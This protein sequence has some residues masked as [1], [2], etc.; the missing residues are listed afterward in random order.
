MNNKMEFDPNKI[1]LSE[2]VT[3]EVSDAPPAAKVK[4]KKSKAKN[5][6]SAYADIPIENKLAIEELDAILE[7][8]EIVEAKPEAIAKPEAVAEPETVAEPEA[9][10]EAPVIEDAPAESVVNEEPKP[11]SFCANCGKAIK[12]DEKFCGNCGENTSQNPVTDEAPAVAVAPAAAIMDSP[13]AAPE[14][15]P[16]VNIYSGNAPAPEE[17]PADETKTKKP[18]FKRF[19]MFFIPWKGD[20]VR[21]VIRKVIFIVALIVFIVAFTFL[22]IYLKNR[23]IYEGYVKRTE[24]LV[25]WDNTT[26]GTDGVLNKYRTLYDKNNDFRGWITIPNTNVDGAVY[27]TLDNSYY[28]NHNGEKKKSNYGAYFVDYKCIISEETSSQNITIYGHHMRDQTMFAQIRKYKDISFYKKNPVIKFETL[29]GGGE[30]KV[31]AAFIT[32]ANPAE[33]NGYFFDYAV[34]GFINQEDFLAWVEQVRRRSLLNTTVDVVEGDDILTLSTCTYELG[35]SKDMR[36]VVMARKI[37]DGESSTVN[38]S[39]ATQNSKPLYPAAW[40]KRFGSKKPTFSDGQ[41]TWGPT[42]NSET[43]SVIEQVQIPSRSEDYS[44]YSPSSYT[45]SRPYIENPFSNPYQSSS[46]PSSFDQTEGGLYDPEDFRGPNDWTEEDFN[47]PELW[48]WGSQQ[49]SSQEASSQT[50]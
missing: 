19:L 45:P 47:N 41:Y 29:Y 25:D 35:T 4:V 3:P 13:V 32:N 7:S 18:L 12:E 16:I 42:T 15:Q 6:K 8:A 24:A 49:A 14:E 36:F 5:A 1:T 46:S 38:V 2:P 39:D 48:G 50:P 11:V 40:Y 21:E 34:Q 23:T 43:T 27:Q 22:A 37:R 31:F 17:A 33:D 26:V 9:V 44:S 10:A 30:Y 20:P 28:I